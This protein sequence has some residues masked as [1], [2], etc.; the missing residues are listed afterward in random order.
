MSVIADFGGELD[1][2]RSTTGQLF[3]INTGAVSRK[4]MLQKTVSLSIQE[5]EYHQGQLLGRHFG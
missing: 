1:T 4:S 2:R 5:A 3:T